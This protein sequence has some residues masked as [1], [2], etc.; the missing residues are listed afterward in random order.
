MK[1]ITHMRILSLLFCF[2]VFSPVNAAPP[3][4]KNYSIDVQPGLTIK[5][6]TKVIIT[7]RFV[8]TTKAKVE[9]TLSIRSPQNHLKILKKSTKLVSKSAGGYVSAYSFVFPAKAHPGVYPIMLEIV[10]N[11]KTDTGKFI[12]LTVLE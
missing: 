2:L 8:V 5:R 4:V 3:L 6:G 12:L 7:S 10:L 9:Q 1:K 11:G